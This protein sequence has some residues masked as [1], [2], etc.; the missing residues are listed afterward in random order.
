[1]SAAPER[2]L[3]RPSGGQ[4]HP[5]LFEEAEKGR[6]LAVDEPEQAG[7][8]I[9][10]QAVESGAILS[11]AAQLFSGVG[12]PQDHLPPSPGPHFRG[13]LQPEGA[14]MAGFVKDEQHETAGGKVL[15]NGGEEIAELRLS[16]APEGYA[17]A[18]IAGKEVD[19]VLCQPVED[20]ALASRGKILM[21]AEKRVKSSVLWVRS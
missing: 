3:F 5:V 18:A 10:Q 12:Q 19:E 1:M 17:S 21:N 15:C 11:A 9:L 8:G 4:R 6:W 7:I 2:I 13:P 16:V 14:L 20:Y